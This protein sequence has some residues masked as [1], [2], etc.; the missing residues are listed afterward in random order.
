MDTMTYLKGVVS[1][2]LDTEKCTG[3]RMCIKVCPHE[4]FEIIEKRAVILNRDACMECGACMRN[5]PEEAIKVN[6]G[7]GCAT[8]VIN[9]ILKGTDPE[10]GCSCDKSGC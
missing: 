6:A 3:C 7:V 10:C 2:E 4:V 9:S 8:A 5:C 1:L